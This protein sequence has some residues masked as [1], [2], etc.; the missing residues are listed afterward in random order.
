MKPLKL[1]LDGL[2][3]QNNINVL[4]LSN[5]EIWNGLNKG[6]FSIN[7]LLNKEDTSRPPYN[8][9]SIDL[10]L[11]HEVFIPTGELPFQFGLSKK[12]IT[13]LLKDNSVRKELSEDQSYTLKKNKLVLVSTLE[14]VNFPINHDDIYYSARVEGKS[15]IARCGILI[16]FTAPTI[17][18]GFEGVIT[19]EIINL[20]SN[21]FL[22]VKDMYICQLIIEEV[23]GC[24]IQTPT[25]FV[26]QNTPVEINSK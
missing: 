13:K 5:I 17:H 25:Q 6:L 14:R 19:L 23:K 26:G 3:F 2:K 18:A 1:Q 12:G 24:P 4:I 15:S 8:T 21:D 11:G 22:L 16:H 10:R 9:S 20:G 7:P